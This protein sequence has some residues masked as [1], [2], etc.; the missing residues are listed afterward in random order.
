M[1]TLT[2]IE[3]PRSLRLPWSRTS[4]AVGIEADEGRLRVAQR[5]LRAGDSRWTLA[6]LEPP[7]PGP[8][9]GPF[10][11]VSGRSEGGP[12]PRGTAICAICSPSVDIF[13]LNLKPSATDPLES[14]VVKHARKLLSVPL[15]S[16]VLD[17]VPLP[18]SVR[19][20]GEE[21][22]TVLV[23][24]AP[25]E[26]IDDVLRR[27]GRSGL[28]VGR[29]ITPACALA[30]QAERSKRGARYLVIA[31]GEE[32]TSVSVVHGGHV[33]LERMLPWS[34]RRL[35]DALC[36]ALGL[37]RP[38]ARGRLE[39]ASN[40]APGGGDTRAQPR[41]DGSEGGDSVSALLRPAFQELTGEA[42]GCMG[43]CRSFLKHA[44]LAG[45]VLAGPLSG[46]AGLRAALQ[47]ELGLPALSAA[48]ELG[49][50]G[51]DQ[52][53]DGAEYVTA[54]CCA[55]WSEGDAP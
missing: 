47:A 27:A 3:S 19:R 21:S 49:L 24:S 16:V 48:E 42:A 35:V 46:S 31:L 4:S 54:A 11:G 44:P 38:E 13:P 30:Q 12:R 37:S 52:G 8:G 26:M 6:V 28:R 51:I 25:K 14:L 2:A 39:A 1:S 22:T 23:F 17:Y 10:R 41:P 36:G 43:Y 34:V 40:G 5:R 55:L 33:L 18:E 50:D 32:A 9:G 20:P 53:D 45:I 15:E 29:V 7:G